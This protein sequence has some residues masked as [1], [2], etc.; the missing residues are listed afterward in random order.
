MK[1]YEI[2]G[3]LLDLTSCKEVVE[4]LCSLKFE[5]CESSYHGLYFICGEKY[6]GENYQIVKNID[7][8]DN[9]LLEESACPVLLYINNI[10]SDKNKIIVESKCFFLISREVL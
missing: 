3:T 10:N 6:N 1:I 5:E 4:S 2:Y 7:L 8:I 9:E